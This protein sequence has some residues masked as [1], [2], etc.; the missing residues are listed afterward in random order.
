[1]KTEDATVADEEEAKLPGTRTQAQAA[2][3]AEKAGE[4]V[5]D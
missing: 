2:A 5:A 3:S 4:S 1:M